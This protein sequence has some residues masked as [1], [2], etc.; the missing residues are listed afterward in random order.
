M[1]YYIRVL[2]NIDVKKNNEIMIVTIKIFGLIFQLVITIWFSFM[3]YFI[4]YCRKNNKF[5]SLSNSFSAG[6]FLS[7]GLIH[8]LPESAEMLKETSDIPLAYILCFF[9]YTLILFIE[10]IALNSHSLL[11]S[12]SH[13]HENHHIINEEKISKNDDDD[14]E[15]N[16][17]SG[18][19][20]KIKEENIKTKENKENEEKS[21]QIF[22]VNINQPEEIPSINSSNS[23]NHLEK[24]KKEYNS[25]KKGGLTSYLLLFALGF[26][27]L[28]EGISLGI[29]SS[30]KETL[31]LFWAISLHKW[32]ASLS[33]GIS[34]VKSGVKKKKFIIMILIF[35][36]I[37]PLGIIFG[38]V[39]SSLSNDT[40][41]GI[42]LSITVGTFI[43]IACSEIIIDEFNSN[44]YKYWKFLCFLLGAAIVIILSILE[45]FFDAGHEHNNRN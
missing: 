18:D 24:I 37:S 40:I 43:Y 4:F 22:S 2:N 44:V 30:I 12:E 35:S 8:I 28:F 31:F 32:A 25:E 33:L 3:P 41:A 23:N 6:I 1:K 45:V 27:G 10:K 7:M 15:K 36:S 42:F 34:F 14:E 5:L 38:M 9:S 19:E 39:L 26:H 13:F 11:H 29:Q 21:E 20:F 16:P 17:N